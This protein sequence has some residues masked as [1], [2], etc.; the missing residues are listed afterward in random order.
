[1]FADDVK[2]VSTL[3]DDNFLPDDLRLIQEWSLTWDLPRNNHKC[4]ILPSEINRYQFQLNNEGVP[5]VDEI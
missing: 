2:I 4:A 1:M 5:Y 3:E